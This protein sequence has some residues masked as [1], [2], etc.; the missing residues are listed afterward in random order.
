[1]MVFLYY[2]LITMNKISSYLLR[3][4][5]GNASKFPKALK[6]NRSLMLA[7]QFNMRHYSIR[8]EDKNTELYK[9]LTGSSANST[10]KLSKKQEDGNYDVD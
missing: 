8:D 5:I 6:V 3:A 1:M 2:K 7:T 9:H 10:N 4:T